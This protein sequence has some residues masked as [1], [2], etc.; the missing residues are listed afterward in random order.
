MMLLFDDICN[1]Y[2]TIF[3]IVTKYGT[4]KTWKIIQSLQKQSQICD[5]IL[6]FIESMS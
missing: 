3:F 5:V 2:V 4:L 1:A 6:T